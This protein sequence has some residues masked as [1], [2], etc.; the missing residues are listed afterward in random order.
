MNLVKKDFDLIEERFTML[1]DEK[2]FLK[3][4]SFAMQLFKSNAYLNKSTKESKLECV[5]NLAQTGL[6]LNPVLKYAYLVPRSVRDGQ[7]YVIKCH[8]EPSYQ[9]L[10]KLVTDT[11]SA[12][13]IYAHVVYE[14]DVFKTTLG[15][16]VEIQHEPQYKSTDITHVY[17]VAL[18]HDGTKQVEVMTLEQIDAIRDMSESY[19]SFK[20]GNAKSCIWNDHFEEMA[21]KTVIK[22]LVKYL[23]KTNMFE[24]LKTAIEIDNVDYGASDAQLDFIDSLIMTAAI[25]PDELESIER[26]KS[27]MTGDRAKELIEYLKANQLDPIHAGVN[28]NQTDI[29]NKLKEEL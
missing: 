13:T 6:T 1:S 22:R 7:D 25:D 14:G 12:K 16:S 5:V 15:T 9:G 17:A 24:K 8:V 29:K 19:K 20:K 11:G 21:K 26:E 18:L 2:T 3:E 10:V 23:P 27:Y 28:Y 4:I